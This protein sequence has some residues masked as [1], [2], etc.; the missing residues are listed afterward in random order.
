MP[1]TSEQLT[2]LV[3]ELLDAHDDTARIAAGQHL[4]ARWAAHLIYLRDLQRV[5]RELLAHAERPEGAQT[6]ALVDVSTPEAGMFRRFG[7]LPMQVLR[8]VIAHAAPPNRKAAVDEA[9]LSRGLRTSSGN[10]RSVR[11]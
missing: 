6:S 8:D 11:A 1:E 5:A 7:R 4:D 3:Y 10:K 2:L 9:V